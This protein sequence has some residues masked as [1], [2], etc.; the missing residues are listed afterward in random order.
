MA[1]YSTYRHYTMHMAQMHTYKTMLKRKGKIC[2]LD[3]YME[4]IGGETV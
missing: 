4:I 1:W 2:K 3:V